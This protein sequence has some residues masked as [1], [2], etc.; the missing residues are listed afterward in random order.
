MLSKKIPLFLHFLDNQTVRKSKSK[1]KSD[2]N[3]HRGGVMSESDS[4]RQRW[5]RE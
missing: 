3:K 1:S 2:K 5:R 4:V